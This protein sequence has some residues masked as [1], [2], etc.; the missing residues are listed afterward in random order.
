M[1]TE[2]EP[3]SSRSVVR[4]YL[5][6]IERGDL[7]AL[8]ATLHPRAEQV[9]YP[10]RLKPGG[11]RRGIDAMARDFE[12]GREILRNQR[13]EVISEVHDADG[14]AIRVLWRGELAIAVGG[15]RPG[16]TMVAHSA[17]VFAFEDGLIRRQFNYDCFEPF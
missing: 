3:T 6:A 14:A 5:S 2:T 9:E 17:I 12:R 1:T 8:L 11:D 7:P 10:N 4:A 15:L 16:D 13:Y